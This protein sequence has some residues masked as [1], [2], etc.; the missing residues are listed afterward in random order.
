MNSF[1]QEIINEDI[2]YVGEGENPKDTLEFQI[3]EKAFKEVYEEKLK[4]YP[5]F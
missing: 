2:V 5:H 1:G 3:W 4:I